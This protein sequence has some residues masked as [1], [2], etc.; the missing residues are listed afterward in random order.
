MYLLRKAL[1]PF[2]AVVLSTGP[3]F[4][5]TRSAS[6]VYPGEPFGIERPPTAFK[7]RSD[8]EFELD[9][10][11]MDWLE[12][13][14]PLHSNVVDGVF[15]Q[16]EYDVEDFITFANT[17]LE[18]SKFYPHLNAFDGII[19]RGDTPKSIDLVYGCVY[20][21]YKTIKDSIEVTTYVTIDLKWD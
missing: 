11:N 9:H 14:G 17:D 16:L 21:E 12:K 6:V 15:D 7:F 10:D 13:G 3:D 4:S 20:R 2:K 5:P 19:K 8:Y 18:A 1:E